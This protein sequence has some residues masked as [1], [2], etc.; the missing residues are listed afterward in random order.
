MYTKIRILLLIH[1]F[2]SSFF[3]HSNFQTLKFFAALFSRTVRSTKLRLGTHM[4]N[5]L[6]Y[7]IYQTSG[8]CCLIIPLF[9][10]F[11]VSPFFFFVKD[12]SAPRILYFGTNFGHDLLYF[13]KENQPSPAYHSLYLSI[14]SSPE[15][16]GS[17]V[18]L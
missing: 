10:H 8:Y 17:L 13:V 1:P 5:G 6:M 14:F 15:P 18:S 9:L 16:L 12:F 11:S 4:V 7:C 3:F 2:I